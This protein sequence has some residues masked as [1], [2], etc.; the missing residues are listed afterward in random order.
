MLFLNLKTTADSEV[1]RTISPLLNLAVIQHFPYYL[2]IKG[3]ILTHHNS[4]ALFRFGQ[5]GTQVDNLTNDRTVMKQPKI[6][7]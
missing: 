2:G 4:S 7:S 6:G 5:V 3:K 1:R